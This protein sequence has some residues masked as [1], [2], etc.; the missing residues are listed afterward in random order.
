LTI[1]R[2]VQGIMDLTVPVGGSTQ[3]V[4]IGVGITDANRDFGSMKRMLVFCLIN[5]SLNNKKG[6]HLWYK[7]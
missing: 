5:V 1:A 2:G 6:T 7:L 4:E 3:S